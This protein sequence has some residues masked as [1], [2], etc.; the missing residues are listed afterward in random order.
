[1]GLR[2]AVVRGIGVFEADYIDLCLS[3]SPSDRRS[4]DSDLRSECRR[5]GN[6]FWFLELWTLPADRTRTTFE[7]R[8]C[9]RWSEMTGRS[10]ANFG[11]TKMTTLIAAVAWTP[12]SIS[13]LFYGRSRGAHKATYR[14]L[15]AES[16]L[17]SE[18]TRRRPV[19]PSHA[20][21]LIR[22]SGGT[23]E[24]SPLTFCTFLRE[25]SS[26]RR[27]PHRP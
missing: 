7:A 20:P 11:P 22:N 24:L 23:A 1:M 26:R 25:L 5:T 15:L 12:A 8:R 21:R 2:V 10:H 17:T 13:P 14:S 9:G 16:K 19:Q 18:C 3:E 27:T 6:S 4:P